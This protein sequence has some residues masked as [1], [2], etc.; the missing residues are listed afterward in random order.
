MIVL[1]TLN[2]GLFRDFKRVIYLDFRLANSTLRLGMAEQNLDG[3]EVRVATNDGFFYRQQ[4]DGTFFLRVPHG[5]DRRPI[6][7]A[8]FPA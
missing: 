6:D 8:I 3:P 5:I 1:K 4:H 7:G 2:L